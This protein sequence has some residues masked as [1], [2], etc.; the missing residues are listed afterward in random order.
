MALGQGGQD[1][2]K[3][4]GRTD[5]SAPTDTNTQSWP[6]TA[7]TTR[8]VFFIVAV[9]YVDPAPIAKKVPCSVQLKTL[10]SCSCGSVTLWGWL[11]TSWIV[12]RCLVL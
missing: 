3:I 1:N 12:L 10:C 6:G 11:T 4:D 2:Q 5:L 8:I 9:F 7:A